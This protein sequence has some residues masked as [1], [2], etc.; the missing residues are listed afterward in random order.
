MPELE[1]GVYTTADK[2]VFFS[3]VPRKNGL[4]TNATSKQ[5][6]H[7]TSTAFDSSDGSIILLL[8][9]GKLCRFTPNLRYIKNDTSGEI[10]S[11]NLTFSETAPAFWN[12]SDLI[13]L[14]SVALLGD[15]MLVGNS[16]FNGGLGKVWLLATYD[17]EMNVISEFANDGMHGSKAF[18]KYLWYGLDANK[19]RALVD[20]V[21]AISS[22]SN[23]TNATSATSFDLNLYKLGTWADFMLPDNTTTTERSFALYKSNVGSV[24]VAENRSVSLAAG[25]LMY[26]NGPSTYRVGQV[27]R[28]CPV[29]S[30][31]DPTTFQCRICPDTTGALFF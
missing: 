14:E 28:L 29:D 22:I 10:I 2:V 15:K 16:K 18:G 21:F 1:L 24:D 19:D 7:R 9:N 20:S 11:K 13:D 27:A 23:L 12:R 5:I 26:I 30:V 4:I 17:A 8:E 31:Y 25:S 3:W 6:V